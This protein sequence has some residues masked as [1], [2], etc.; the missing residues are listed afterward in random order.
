M[1][2][3]TLSK[4]HGVEISDRWI[5]ALADSNVHLNCDK[6]CVGFSDFHGDGDY[7]LIIADKGAGRYNMYLKVFKGVTFIGESVLVD[8]PTGILSF[9]SESQS[10]TH[11]AVVPSIA[12]A[13]GTAVLIFKNLKPFYKYT[14][15]SLDPHQDEVRAW[16]RFNG[17]QING[18]QLHLILSKLKEMVCEIFSTLKPPFRSIGMS[19]L[20]PRSQNYLVVPEADRE[21]FLAQFRDKPVTRPQTI[22]AMTSLKRNSSELDTADVFVVAT[23]NGNI[24]IVDPYAYHLLES[25]AVPSTPVFLAS[26]GAYDDEYRIAVTT[27]DSEIFVI[28]RGTVSS[29]PVASMRSDIVSICMVKK[30]LII[31]CS[32]KTVSFYSL[33][34]KFFNRLKLEQPV[35]CIEPFSYTPRQYNGVFVVHQKE[36]L[37]HSSMSH[38]NPFRS[39]C[40][41]L[42]VSIFRRTADLEEQSRARQMTG[43]Q[44]IKGNYVPKKTKIYVDHTIREREMAVK[45]HQIYQRDLF[46]LKLDTAKTYYNLISSSGQENVTTKAHDSLELSI[47]VNGFG[48]QFILKSSITSNLPMDPEITRCIVYQWDRD[49]YTISPTIIMLP[50]LI[51]TKSYSFSSTV[52]VNHPENFQ[53]EDI[54]VLVVEKGSSTPLAIAV[55]TMPT[56]ELPMF[57]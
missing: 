38:C 53:S 22:T 33:K 23:E 14:L 12:V 27:R 11:E 4:Q 43:S 2:T 21:H 10:Q 29:K 41:G 16:Q 19:E 51:H 17:G 45:M 25:V 48:P 7:K 46:M 24:Y 47:E 49:I 36:V 31:A 44:Q 50:P 30:Q 37:P 32:D 35:I 8:L 54:K 42:A 6:E 1:L 57:D 34:G 40:G 39:N 26:Y 55:V 18:E 15:P 20:S 3:T 9:S 28:K 56:S 52:T 13:T 5:F